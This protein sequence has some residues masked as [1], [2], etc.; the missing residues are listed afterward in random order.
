MAARRARSTRR[1]G[2][3]GLKKGHTKSASWRK[4][5]SVSL[6]AAWKAGKFKGRR[7]RGG[8][9]TSVRR[10]GARRTSRTSRVRRASSARRAGGRKRRVGRPK[11]SKNK[12]KRRRPGT[13]T[14]A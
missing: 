9:K 13:P 3:R 6:K 4:A 14:F 1:T 8:R 11:G 2:K 5:L 7:R 12:S 10:S